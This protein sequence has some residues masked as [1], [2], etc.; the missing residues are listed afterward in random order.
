MEIPNKKK[1]EILRYKF[2]NDRIGVIKNQ[3]KIKTEEQIIFIPIQ[4]RIT[5]SQVNFF[6]EFI[7]MGII[8]DQSRSVIN[9]PIYVYNPTSQYVEIQNLLI[10]LNQKLDCLKVVFYDASTSEQSCLS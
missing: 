5:S 8:D 1:V 4:V 7:D 3:I 10:S 2:R 6:R 9:M